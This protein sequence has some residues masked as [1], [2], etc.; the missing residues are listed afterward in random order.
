[1]DYPIRPRAWDA[2]QMALSTEKQYEVA[3]G[4]LKAFLDCIVR[5]RTAMLVQCLTLVG[6]AGLL[7]RENLYAELTFVG[8][9]GIAFSIALSGLHWNYLCFYEDIREFLIT[10]EELHGDDCHAFY[11]PIERRRDHRL[12]GPRY[13]LVLY[14]PSI[15]SI[16][17][18]LFII[19]YGLMHEN[20]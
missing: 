16:S 7:A 20:V 15:L 1:M 3:S 5:T 12:R 18:M 9:F 2:T 13:L 8:V 11:G 4:H 19:T 6:L 17:S 14:S 10:L